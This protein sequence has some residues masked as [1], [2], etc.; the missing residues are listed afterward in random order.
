MCI[1]DSNIIGQY[2]ILQEIPQAN[3]LKDILRIY[4]EMS[5][6]ITLGKIQIPIYNLHAP[7]SELALKEYYKT[8]LEVAKKTII[9][10]QAHIKRELE[11]LKEDL[12]LSMFLSI[13]N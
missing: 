6:G 9:G 5:Q 8:L 12:L 13:M 3:T 2:Y 1:R 11:R 10:I 4:L 7:Y